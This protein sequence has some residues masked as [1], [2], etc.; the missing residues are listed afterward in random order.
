M[1]PVFKVAIGFLLMPGLLVASPQQ[2]PSGTISGTVVRYGF[3]DPVANAT[4]TVSTARTSQAYETLLN[5]GEGIVI[6]LQRALPDLLTMN[7]EDFK[8]A[9][10]QIRSLPLPGAFV[11]AMNQLQAARDSAP[12]FPKSVLAD[13]LGRFT[14]PD[15]PPGQYSI[16]AQHDGFFGK[17]V[18]GS[19]DL[20][21]FESVPVTVAAQR[22][23]TDVSITLVAGA[24][25]SGHVFDAAG[26]PLSNGTVQ[27]IT[28]T[29]QN[30]VP[31][32]QVQVSNNTD[33]RGAFRL[34]YLPPG[35]YFVAANPRA[36]SGPAPVSPSSEVVSKTFYPNSVSA[37]MSTPVP[38]R[39]G[40]EATGHGDEPLLK[41][42]IG[43]SK[44]FC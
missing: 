27:A 31:G 16:T 35:E 28:L 8:D 5:S 4:V 6:P 39:L 32:L 24:S 33:D 36:P 44:E 22:T 17:P 20:R 34:F 13:T 15:L 42:A 38:V 7:A 11:T 23:T 26:Q 12:G 40:D 30:G 29:Y 9:M 10:T 37:L 41:C 14:I 18:A 25:I 3:Q 2:S 21:T 1:K 43:I 19:S